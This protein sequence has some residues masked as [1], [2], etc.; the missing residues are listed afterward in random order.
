MKKTILLFLVLAFIS[1]TSFS[2]VL[3]QEVKKDNAKT[4]KV[5][6]KKDAKKVK[7]VKSTKKASKCDGCKSKETCTKAEKKVEETKAK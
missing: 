2:V 6:V 3:S 5:E 7:T 1:V 4:T